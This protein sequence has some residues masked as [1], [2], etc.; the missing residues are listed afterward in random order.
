MVVFFILLL[1]PMAMQHIVIGSADINYEKKNRRA[2][3]VFF[4]LLT[5]LVACRHE[6]VGNDTRNYVHFFERFSAMSWGEVGQDSLEYGYAYFNKVVSLFSKEP[7]FFLVVAAIA[8]SAMI[9]PTYKRLCLD[10]T[11]SIVLFCTISTFVM[12]FSGIRQ[13]L[14]IGLG[15]IAYDL[16]RKRKLLPFVLVVCSAVLFHTSAFILIFMYPLYH[17][18]ITKKWLYIVVP[19]I[20][21]VF[22]FNRQIFS[23][24]SV[25]IERYTRFTGGVSSTGA[26]TMLFLFGLFTVFSFV[27][28]GDSKLDQETIGLRN[29]LLFSL[30]LQMFTPL[31]VLAMR[32]NYYYIIFIPLLLP[33]IIACRNERWSQVAI[34]GRH[35]MVVFFLAYFLIN[36]YTTA[37]T[38][39]CLHVFPYHFFWENIA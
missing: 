31:H 22:L 3:T 12:S 10:P 14:A 36:V 27:V 15:F 23:V 25:I 2:L 13:M 28:P 20:A 9:Y 35:V 19:V 37:G 24:L 30:V 8:V 17:A 39:S 7:Q 5:I 1:V 18:K 11:L 38:S 21:I 34:L 32:M 26:Y 33:K 6:S 4:V 16:T 29:F